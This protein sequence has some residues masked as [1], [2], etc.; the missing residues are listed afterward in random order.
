M[1]AKILKFETKTRWKKP[2]S[3]FFFLL[4]IFQSIWFTQGAYTYYA[5]EATL[6]NG[7]ALFYKNFAGGGMIMIIIVA[8][9]T[10]GVLFKDIQHKSAGILYTMPINEKS[11]FLGRFLAALSTNLILGTGLF[12]GMLLVPYSGI[13]SAD[14]FGPT[15]W[16][17]ML[18]G[19]FLLTV[20]NLFLLTVACFAALVFFRKMAAGY[21]GI[22]VVAILF[23][24]TETIRPN[25]PYTTF[26]Q[27]LDPFGYGYTTEI[28]DTLPATAKNTTYLP[29]T[30][31]YFIHK[32]IWTGGA[33]LLLIIS[34][35]K[36]S[37]KYFIKA[38]SPKAKKN[39]VP[40][41]ETTSFS[42][43]IGVPEVQLFFSAKEFIKKLSRL[44]VLEFKNVIRPVNFKVIMIM[45]ALMFFLQNLVW[46]P[47]YYLGAQL[48]TTASMTLTRITTG[49][50]I[51]ILL[52]IW[53]VELFFK[54]KTSNIWQITDALPVPVW[55]S[56]F[57][58]YL[59]MCGVAF[60]LSVTIILC[61]ILAQVAKGGWEHIDLWLYAEDLLGYKWGWLTYVLNISFAFFIAGLTGNRFAT[62]V[63]TVGYY[64]FNLISVEFDIIEEIRYTYTL[65]P[66]VEDFSEIS[67]YGIWNLASNW[68][69]LL[70]ATLAII[71]VLLG[72]HFWRR[73]KAFDF[74]RKITFRTNQL[75]IYGKGAVLLM[76]IAFISLQ[77]FIVSEVNE[78]GNF[79]PEEVLNSQ[80]ASYEKKYKRILSEPQPKITHA[81]LDIAL[82]PEERKAISKAALTLTNDC[83]HSIDTVYLSM[84]PFTTIK[85]LLWNHSPIKISK[86]DEELRMY[87]IPLSI[88]TAAS[89][90]LSVYSQKE[91]S[92]FTQKG[93]NPQPELLFNGS[94]FSIREI[95]P[96][97]GYDVHRE[98]KKNRERIEHQLP[99]VENRMPSI[100][101][102]IAM[103][104]DVFAPDAKWLTGKIQ[105]STSKTQFAV[106]PG[107]LVKTW[108]DQQRSHYMYEITEPT[109]FAWYISS[110]EQEQLQFRTHDV[111]VSI[112]H[113]K[114]HHYNLIHYQEAI[115][116]TL[117]FINTQ[118]GNYPYSE[119]RMVEIPFY[120]E[121]QYSY[122]NTIATSEKEGWIADI[123]EIPE[124]SY[125]TFLT[126]SQL[127]RQW[128]YRNIHIANVQGAD[129][130]Q[131]ALPEALALQI[132]LEKHGAE[133]VHS[134]L[135]KKYNAYIKERG[136]DPN[137][138][139]PLLYTDGAPYLAQ[140]KG[141]LVLYK[142][143]KKMGADT[144]TLVVKNSIRQF[145]D[146][147]VPF[148]ALYRR[149]LVNLS[150]EDQI[151]IKKDIETVQEIPALLYDKAI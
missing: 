39:I 80:A 29:L 61:G 108:N 122:A 46:N 30:Y 59:A 21:L 69:F 112:L 10:G 141:T 16:G 132:V 13:G 85:K 128:V 138:E 41:T 88:D 99:R 135:E 64:L 134:I 38:L 106:A 117:D 11:F 103:Q 140:N 56:Q 82:Y 98:L 23:M 102:A 76:V 5:N 31:M 26:L 105:L 28:L 86:K 81:E 100:E 3:W 45:V 110:S 35:K 50:A 70:W 126:A 95:I 58:K 60:I 54:D 47:T 109:P 89:G 94:F 9:V 130:L 124:Q 151:E 131:T 6:M 20:P 120:Q 146:T 96:T 119:N 18:E 33:I 55:V 137:T 87:A 52:M 113:H 78:K 129:M 142:M 144:F 111:D 93:E 48:P 67:G 1:I 57:S 118:L 34:Y 79:Q 114:K 133:G 101:N 75:N 115:D 71:F 92:G 125:L 77:S 12:V 147:P 44:A 90:V 84:A 149:F 53:S 51:M 8:I 32:A 15:P 4:M 19:F 148:T 25:T 22:F 136:N 123:Q 145:R 104:Q 24:V 40:D 107:K 143:M 72:I 74:K 116:N 49:A 150:K 66:G 63:L 36:F 65:T 2:I 7:A 91:Y 127:I 121:K 14:K 97:I 27:L 17:Q 62:H 37:F 139:I 83:N 42:S 68:F 43:D 73:G